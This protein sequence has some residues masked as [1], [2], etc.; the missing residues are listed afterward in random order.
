M[1]PYIDDVLKK[2]KLEFE[3]KQVGLKWG[4]FETIRR[5]GISLEVGCVYIGTAANCRT[6]VEQRRSKQALKQEE[7]RGMNPYIN[8]QAD[9]V[10][11]VG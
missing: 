9:G 10:I 1:M 7:M 11:S 8:P 3:F 2:Q 5:E 6:Y 4:V